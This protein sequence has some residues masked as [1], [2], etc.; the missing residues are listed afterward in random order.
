MPFR[1]EFANSMKSGIKTV[2]SRTFKKTVGDTF[3]AFDM[4][5]MIT[6]VERRTLGF[7]RDFQW[8]EE[9]CSSPADFVRIWNEIH[10]IKGFDEK[11]MINLHRFRFLELSA[12]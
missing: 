12:H 7:V 2:T 11:Q 1:A 4:E 3:T 5:F 9:G 8:K 10:P 6:A